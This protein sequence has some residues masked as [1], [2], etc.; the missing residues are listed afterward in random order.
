MTIISVC[1]T[2]ASD[3]L[4]HMRPLAAAESGLA[5][6]LLLAVDPEVEPLP[7]WRARIAGWLGPWPA[8]APQHD[9]TQHGAPQHGAMTLRS[10]AGVI[11]SLILYRLT[12][13]ARLGSLLVVDLLRAI[14]PADGRHVD[15]LFVDT[16]PHGIQG[17]EPL[18]QGMVGGQSAG[19]PLIQMMVGVDQAGRED[20]AAAVDAD[21]VVAEPC[22]HRIVRVGADSRDGGAV[23][24]YP[25][26]A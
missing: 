9:A 15:G 11:V 2:P 12:P 5:Y 17:G 20:A 26:V 25:A 16:R 13:D 14:E 1:Q 7:A 19:D 24:K 8:R 23:D 4:W 21:H 3:G 22:D 18:E 10:A 6:P